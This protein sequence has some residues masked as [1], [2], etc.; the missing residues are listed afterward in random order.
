MI[1]L[2]GCDRDHLTVFCAYLDIRDGL[3]LDHFY[4]EK[5]LSMERFIFGF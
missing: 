3:P 1:G 4:I 2:I 5:L